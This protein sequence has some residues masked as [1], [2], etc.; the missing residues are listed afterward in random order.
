MSF[1]NRDRFN[2]VIHDNDIVFYTTS[3]RYGGE[4][5]GK[6]FYQITGSIGMM[7]APYSGAYQLNPPA[8]GST[9]NFFRPERRWYDPSTAIVITGIVPQ[10]LIDKLDQAYS[11]WRQKNGNKT[12]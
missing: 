7:S 6:V 8:P 10:I 3:S 4:R 5:V 2:N 9:V 1:T 12:F 11:E